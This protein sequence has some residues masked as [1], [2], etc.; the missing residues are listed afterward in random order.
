METASTLDLIGSPGDLVLP[1]LEPDARDIDLTDVG[2]KRLA[3]DAAEILYAGVEP[4]E[5]GDLVEGVIA[6]AGDERLQ[7][8]LDID[9]IY[10]VAVTIE[11][12]PLKLE[13]D[14]VMVGVKLVLGTPIATD[15]KMLGDEISLDGN[16]VHL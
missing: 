15:E 6:V 7:G 8:L 11:L 13:L 16:C 10:Q 4:F 2:G 5:F 12:H 9:D 14:L 1:Q 3:E